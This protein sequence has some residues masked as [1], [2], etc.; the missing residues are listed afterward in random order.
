[1][2]PGSASYLHGP[3]IVS[4]HPRLWSPSPH[5]AVPV[6]PLV[7]VIRP[8][9]AVS[10]SLTQRGT[11]YK[12]SR[13]SKLSVFTLLHRVNEET[14]SERPGAGLRSP[15]WARAAPL[16]P[17]CCEAL[18]FPSEEAVY[19]WRGPGG[20][21]QEGLLCTPVPFLFLCFKHK[22]LG[23]G[24]GLKDKGSR[25]RTGETDP[26]FSFNGQ[27]PRRAKSRPGCECARPAWL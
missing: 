16:S 27:S 7:I 17:Q 6:L 4:R 26:F 19:P 18:S 15:S 20:P 22:T 8:H 10:E 21:S 3:R 13:W 12:T 23:L 5:R 24:L 2:G 1:M 14:G 9:P 25:N 11:S